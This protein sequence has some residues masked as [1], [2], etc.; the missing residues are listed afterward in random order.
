MI[1]Y[2]RDLSPFVRR[3]AIWCDLQERPIE[4]RKLMVSGPEWEQVK[5]VNPT[6]R[7]PAL[8]LPDG[9]VLVESWAIMDWLEETAA[10]HL[11]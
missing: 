4:R 9:E 1:L 2:G 5:A 11:R 3:I 10:P 6:G 8:V 7:V